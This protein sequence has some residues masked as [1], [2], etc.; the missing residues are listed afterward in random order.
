MDFHNRQYDPQLGRFLSL[1][2]MA[3]AAGQQ[4]LSPYHPMAC[5]PST[6]VDPLGLYVKGEAH[7]GGGVP[8]YGNEIAMRFPTMPD[9][10]AR[11]LTFGDRTADRSMAEQE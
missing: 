8:Q 7:N 9:F 5:N 2:P 11:Y 4:G 6:M 1:D 3:D 10:M